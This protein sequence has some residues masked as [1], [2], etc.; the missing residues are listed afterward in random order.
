[1]GIYES[2]GVTPIINATGTWTRLGGSLM[3]PEVMDA[4]AQASRQFVSLE[5]L[6]YQAGR[7][8]AELID[9]P[10]AYVVSGCYAGVVLSI[11]ACLAG[12]DPRK[13][14][15][16]PDTSGM[17]R[18]VVMLAMQRNSYDHAVE[19]PGGPIVEA[20]TKDSG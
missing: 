8:I 14:N 4:M 20:G 10:A 15:I 9:A 7:R 16:L 1:M 2:L 6:Q 12:S 3:A 13:M 11:A 19:V 18:S 17:K 5:E